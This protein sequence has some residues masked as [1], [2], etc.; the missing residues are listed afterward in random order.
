MRKYDLIIFDCDGTLV[1][2]EHPNNLA[3]CQ[4]LEENG[5]MGYDLEHAYQHWM[6]KTLSDIFPA[7]EKERDVKLPHDIAQQTIKR[8]QLLYDTHLKAI[9][10]APESVA[11]IAR[12]YKICVASNGERGSVKKGLSQSGFDA[13]FDEDNIFTRIQVKNPK[14]APDLFLLAAEKMK[15]PPARCLVIEDSMTG[16][17]GAVAAN[18]PVWGFTGVSHAP[19]EA[20]KSLKK[21]GAKEVFEHLIHIAERLVP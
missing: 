15:V 16:V 2:S 10:E 18:M 19:V 9:P 5:V 8:I 3:I 7:V 17:N 1:N 6:G 13:F 20:Q 14:P 21:A 4:L 12:N 11:R